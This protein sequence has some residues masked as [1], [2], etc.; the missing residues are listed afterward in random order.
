MIRY[1]FI[2]LLSF[3]FIFFLGFFSLGAYEE[4]SAI[5]DTITVIDNGF[6]MS[7]NEEAVYNDTIKKAISSLDSNDYK[8]AITL[9]DN[10]LTLNPFS[11]EAINGKG[12]SLSE[13][14]KH[15]EAIKLYDKALKIDPNSKQV[16]NNKG[17]S[18]DEVG[19]HQEA[20][21]LYD[22]ALKIDP[23][24]KTSFKQ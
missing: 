8:N 14:G 15:Q 4:I 19:K 13:L 3:Y 6:T 21:K 20:I 11:I 17:Y 12:L 9:Y 2:F 22:K 23:N 5:N 24:S 1:F 16:L 10:A 7:L 18:L